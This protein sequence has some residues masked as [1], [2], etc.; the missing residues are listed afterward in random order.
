MSNKIFRNA[1]P[2]FAGKQGATYEE[3]GYIVDTMDA[4]NI[5]PP[6]SGCLLDIPKIPNIPKFSRVI[7]V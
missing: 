1:S 3:E 4:G 5:D 6:D 2:E 7:G